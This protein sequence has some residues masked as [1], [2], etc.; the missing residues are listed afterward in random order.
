MQQAG[1]SWSQIAEALG[2]S[3]TSARRLC[4]NSP[5]DAGREVPTALEGRPEAVGPLF[6]NST[7]SVPLNAPNANETPTESGT[8]PPEREGT[9]PTLESFRIFAELLERVRREAETGE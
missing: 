9:G 6:R 2:I 8:T 7:T 3:R 1:R 4:Q 5:R